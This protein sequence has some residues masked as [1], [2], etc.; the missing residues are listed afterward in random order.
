LQ[1]RQ[2]LSAIFGEGLPKFSSSTLKIQS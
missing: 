2:T 1:L